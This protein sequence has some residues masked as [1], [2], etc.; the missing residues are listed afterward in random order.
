MAE[1]PFAFTGWRMLSGF[2]MECGCAGQWAKRRQVIEGKRD[3][4][5]WVFVT[6]VMGNAEGLA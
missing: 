6:H 1:F 3:R 5:F 2:R 4:I